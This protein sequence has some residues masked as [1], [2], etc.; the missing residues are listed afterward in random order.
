MRDGSA[1]E[2][3][4]HFRPYTARS[5]R[6]SRTQIQKPRPASQNSRRHVKLA[7]SPSGTVVGLTES[8]RPGDHAMVGPPMYLMA[9]APAS[10]HRSAYDAVGYLLFNTEPHTHGTR[11]LE[12][13]G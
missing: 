5:A 2:Y 10:V 8:V 4:R 6:A 7:I 12:Q 9:V 1:Q 13:Q 3:D 11:I